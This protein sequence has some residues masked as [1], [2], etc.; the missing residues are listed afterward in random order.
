MPTSTLPRLLLAAL[1][2]V[3]APLALGQAGLAE[4]RGTIRDPAG[5]PVAMAKVTATEQATN[6]RFAVLTGERGHY[7]VL[8]LP[9]GRYALSVERP[10]FRTYRHEGITLRIADQAALD[11]KLELGPQAQSVTVAAEAPLLQTAGGQASYSVERAKL[12]AMP[13]DGR[14]FVPLIALAPGVALPGGGS[15]LPRINGSRP[16]TN[17]YIYDGISVLQPEPGQV[18]F[19]PLLDAIEEF[20]LNLNSYSPEYGRSNGGAVI[21]STKSGGNQLHGTVFEFLR[22]EDLNARNYFAPAGAR[23]EFRRN[24]YGFTLG[25]PVRKDRMF[26]FADWQGTRL[27][28]G[29]TRF[30]TVPNAAQRQGAFAAAV[31]DPANGLPFPDNA[32]PERRFD[33]VALQVLRHYPAP[34]RPGAANNYARTA[35]EP[36]SQDQ[37]DLRLDRYYR[38][39]HR[40]FGR[41]SFLRDDDDPVTPLPDG[42]GTL[43]SGVTGHAITRGD[44][45]VAEYDWSASPAAFNTARFGYTRRRLDQASLLNGDIAV[46]GIPPNSFTAALPA[47]T[48]AGYQQVGPTPGANDHFKTSVTEYLDTFSWARGSHTSKLGVD[49]RREALD[50]LNPP[51]PS[52]A[53]AFTS[54]GT[55]NPVASLL[56]GQVNAFTIDIQSQALQERAHIAEFFAG[57]EWKVS[58]RLAV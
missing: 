12:A 50:V 43:T 27:R 28:T 40:V 31:I 46:P 45:L 21:V 38:T 1:L 39:R 57:D 10:G 15:L 9:P 33:P 34:N 25:G 17:E 44:G 54:A 6:A 8:G 29:I 52:G 58:Q 24:Q 48:V 2:P 32:I 18:A 26:F 7:H 23:P 11:V 16:R 19:Y 5:L 56:L 22:N 14:N 3:S 20:R 30:S 53:Y 37:F 42:S 47:F 36:D 35:A 51:N 13:L 49:L 41:Y 4:L 55:G